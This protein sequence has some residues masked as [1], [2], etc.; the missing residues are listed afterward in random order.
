[1]E[2]KGCILVTGGLGYI[3]SHTVVA[4]QEKGYE[5]VVV[6]NLSNARIEVLQLI[7]RI[8]GIEPQFYQADC[9]DRAAIAHVFDDLFTIDGIIHFAAYGVEEELVENPLKI[10]RN[11]VDSLLTILEF[12]QAF[13]IPNFVLSSSASVYPVSTASPITEL[14]PIALPHSS[15]GLTKVFAEQ[16]LQSVACTYKEFR[17]VALRYYYPIGAHPSGFLGEFPPRIPQ[18]IMHEILP[19]A[20]YHNAE[21]TIHGSDYPTP[22]GT[23]QWDFFHVCDL[24]RAHVLALEY[25]ERTQDEVGIQYVNVGAGRGTSV[26]EL[27]ENFEAIT[28]KHIPYRIDAKRIGEAA[29]LWL[30]TK[31]AWRLL[32]WKP[33][34]DL[35]DTLRDA[36]KWEERIR[37]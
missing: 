35:V 17:C 5:V 24:A 25:L 8:S 23:Q 1:M 29:E 36:W 28:G 2:E 11:N 32:G 27:I 33:E 13:G 4:L 34:Y 19:I 31:K 16:L 26:L 6:D 30:D 12:A 37:G 18:H 9:A 3:G 10:Y 14:S 15:V 20:C 7:K 21:L 22:D